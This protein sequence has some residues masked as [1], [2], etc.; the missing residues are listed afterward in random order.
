NNI[1]RGPC[2]LTLSIENIGRSWQWENLDGGGSV[3]AVW[4]GKDIDGNFV[5]DGIYNYTAY[6]VQTRSN[7][8]GLST[9]DKII[10]YIMPVAFAYFSDEETGTITVA[11]GSSGGGGTIGSYVKLLS[12]NGGENWKAGETH[13]IQWESQELD[14]GNDISIELLPSVG[15]VPPALFLSLPNNTNS[16]DWIIPENI[17]PGEYHLW[18]NYM[19]HDGSP[20]YE[21]NHDIS[22]AAFN[23][24]QGNPLPE[25]IK[26]NQYKADGTTILSEGAT[27]DN[28]GIIFKY[29]ISDPNSYQ[30]KIQ[31]ELQPKN[32]P[33][34]ESGFGVFTSPSFVPY[35]EGSQLGIIEGLSEGEYHWRARA[36]NING[37]AS[38]WQEFEVPG[39]TD[40]IVNNNFSD[41]SFVHIT[42]VHI[43]SNTALIAT[44]GPW[45]KGQKSED[46]YEFWSYPRFTDTLYEIG[47]KYSSKTSLLK[48]PD[49]IIISGDNVEYN[50]PRWLADFKSMIDD[51]T[52]KTGIEIYV[53]PGNHDRFNS[54]STAYECK[55]DSSYPCD[56]SGGDD[57]LENYSATMGK[58]TGVNVLFPW[59]V[60]LPTSSL[61]GVDRYNYFFNHEGIQFIGLDSG[62]D[63]SDFQ[64]VVDTAPESAGLS[65]ATMMSLKDMDPAVPKIIF[66]H[67]P[68][69]TDGS[70]PTEQEFENES[71]SDNRREFVQYVDSNRV[72][73]SEFNV[74]NN[75]LA[76]FSGHTHR[77]A[78][79]NWNGTLFT[80]SPLEGPIYIQTRSATKDGSNY[81]HGYRIIDVKNGL[82]IP[83]SIE[84]TGFYDKIIVDIDQVSDVANNSIELKAYKDPASLAYFEKKDPSYFA[85]KLSERM[86]LYDY[87]NKVSKFIMYNTSPVNDKYDL[88]VSKNEKDYIQSEYN[89]F[90]FMVKN[91]QFCEDLLS[92][93]KCL[94]GFVVIFNNIDNSD[95]K[96]NF[97]KFID[98]KIKSGSQDNLFINWSLLPLTSN[99]LLGTNLFVN[100]DAETDFEKILNKITIQLH[101]PGQLQVIDS[102]GRVSGFE[103]GEVK[104]EIPY[105]IYDEVN[106]EVIL[107]VDKGVEDEQYKYKVVGTNEA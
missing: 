20:V 89:T 39:N 51:F 105:S 77:D 63:T 12:P 71:I 94:G 49:F 53:V 48:R 9:F 52:F 21:K 93:E 24:V 59:T 10:S 99:T 61:G 54:E 18:I 92:D 64:D 35:G 78:I 86:I 55:N 13:T 79:H 101:S 76:V 11:Y 17:F 87:E 106:E 67:N 70:Y 62:E 15:T 57:R 8:I 85:A 81:K 41:F 95:K 3:Q 84:E 6:C 107:F 7:P 69:F 31:I 73:Y 82:V 102:D 23:I 91:K 56:W 40:F 32:I 60:D 75:V 50:D 88:F 42:D 34:N 90:G 1:G 27:I 68:I 65:Y 16:V 47:Y 36:I 22:D 44:Y 100:N 5:S 43:G 103:N 25:L 30:S 74:N 4:D 33:F 98:M 19:T 2:R 28:T 66:M 29:T 83:N 104:E 96:I 26:V 80:E 97:L 14:I 46:W 38:A 58:Q 45:F 37:N 72:D